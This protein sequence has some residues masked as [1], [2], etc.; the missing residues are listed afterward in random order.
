MTKKQQLYDI[1]QLPAEEGLMI[2]F[3]SMSKISNVQKAENYYEYLEHFLN[4]IKKTQGIGGVI[5]YS[6]YLYLY[7]DPGTPAQLRAKYIELMIAH[8][9][10]F[11]RMLKK[12]PELIAK[13]YTFLTWGQLLLNTQKFTS[14]LSDLK[15]IYEKDEL[16]QK[17]VA[18]DSA[19]RSITRG[20]V[21]FIMEECLVFYL[22]SKGAF[23]LPSDYIQHR[24][25]WILNCYPGP[26]L[27]TEAYLYQK[28]PF[29]LTNS[30]NK[31][32]N[33]YYDL[34]KKVLHDLTK[35]LLSSLNT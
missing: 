22:S 31:Y 26:P 28:N 4:K 14:Y 21:N 17:C 11:L 24:E 15:T 9:N 20:Q 30:K 25:Q 13:A 6:D 3:V 23:S 19:G 27:L 2:F 5:L 18:K 12:R 35:I 32:E 10:S 7:T 33:A 8:K 1:N 29:N 34:D 16:L